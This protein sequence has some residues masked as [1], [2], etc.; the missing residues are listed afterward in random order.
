MGKANLSEYASIKRM[1]DDELKAHI[2]YMSHMQDDLA[3]MDW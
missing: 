2:S 1:T 3:N